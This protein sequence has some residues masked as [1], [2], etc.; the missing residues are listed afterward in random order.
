MLGEINKNVELQCAWRQYCSYPFVTMQPREE[1][2]WLKDYILDLGSPPRISRN[3]HEG[4]IYLQQRPS[5]MNHICEVANRLFLRMR[6]PYRK[7]MYL[8]Q[9]Q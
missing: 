4:S 3:E 8:N 5:Q 6:L 7:N 9:H 1:L 2:A